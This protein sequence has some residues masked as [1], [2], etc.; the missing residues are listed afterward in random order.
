MELSILY[1][2]GMQVHFSI[3][4]SISVPAFILANSEDHD[5]MVHYAAFHLG[6]HCF[7]KYLFT[8]IQ[9][10]SLQTTFKQQW[11]SSRVLDS[12]PRG[13]GFEPHLHHCIVVLEQDKFILA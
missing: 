13:S 7:P 8:D 12:R 10:G 6:L 4:W 5:E 1:F 2:K 3:K 11:F 9:N